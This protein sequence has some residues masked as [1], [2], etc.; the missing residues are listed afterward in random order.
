MTI[1][2]FH[3]A[4]DRPLIARL[5]TRMSNFVVLDYISTKGAVPEI[6]GVVGHVLDPIV[7][8]HIALAQSEK[9]AGHVLVV[10]TAV[11]DIVIQNFV[12]DGISPLLL[13]VLVV[14]PNQCN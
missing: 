14:T 13:W 2:V 3:P 10:H 12:V 9:D 7:S 4:I 8:D 6:D 11:M 5:E 1:R